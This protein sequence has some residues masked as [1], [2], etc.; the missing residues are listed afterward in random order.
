MRIISVFNILVVDDAVSMLRAIQ[1]TLRE[2]Y[3]EWI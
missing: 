1:Y 2:R 3:I